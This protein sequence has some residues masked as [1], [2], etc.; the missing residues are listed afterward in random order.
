M[1]RE[2]PLRRRLMVL[3]VASTL[4]LAVMA[5]IGLFALKR[6]QDAQTRQVG[7]ELARSIAN[8]VD[9]EQR[10]MVSVLETLAT[11]PSLDSD[12]YTAFLI[13][14]RRVVS[15]RPDWAQIRLAD[16]AGRTRR[17]YEGC[18]GCRTAVADREEELH[19]HP[20]HQDAG[21]RQPGAPRRRGVAFRR[22]R[23]RVSRQRGALR[24]DGPGLPAR[25]LP[26]AEPATCPARLAD[27]DC[28]RERFASGPIARARGERRRPPG[29]ERPAGRRPW[30]GR[31]L[32]HRDLARG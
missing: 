20:P 12:D 7:V 28:R 30:R 31:G 15:A 24:A 16:P 14:A 29:R 32:R 27:L 3:A 11:T 1:R 6:Q 5:A 8:A 10:S 4:P 21:G 19:Q 25:H 2:T 13:R 9:A 26:G 22:A 23:P 18:F 17:R